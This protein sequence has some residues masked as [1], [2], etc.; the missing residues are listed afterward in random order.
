[1]T[2]RVWR[3]EKA[4]N[5]NLPTDRIYAY[6][7]RWNTLAEWDPTVSAVRQLTPG[8]PDASLCRRTALGVA[9]DPHDL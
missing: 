8:T 4:I 7:H 3:V 2:K 5:L 9:A 1:M 6:L